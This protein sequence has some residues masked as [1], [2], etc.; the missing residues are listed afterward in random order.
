M[1]QFGDF[2]GPDPPKNLDE[3]IER[4]QGQ[5]AQAQS[6]MESLAPEDRQ[7][8]EDLLQSMLDDATQFELAKMA[9]NLDMLFPSD[10]LHRQYPFTGE[11]SISYNEAL[12]LMEMLQKMDRLEEQFRES[13]YNLSLEVTRLP[14]LIMISV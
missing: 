2:F 12:K 7:T 14:M 4:L 1:E 3:L 13:Q 5:I 10:R 11:E 6:L 9:A 8:L